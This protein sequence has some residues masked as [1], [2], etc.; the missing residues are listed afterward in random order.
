MRAAL[1]CLLSVFVCV[2]FALLVGCSNVS[3]NQAYLKHTQSIP[4][5][6]TKHIQGVTTDYRVSAIPPR[7]SAQSPSLVPPGSQF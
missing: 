3:A 1:M 5:M 7:T 2:F 6:N 4:V